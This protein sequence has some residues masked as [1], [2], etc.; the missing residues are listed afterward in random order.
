MTQQELKDIPKTPQEARRQ[1]GPVPLMA[2]FLALGLFAVLFLFFGL[3][4]IDSIHDD[5]QGTAIESRN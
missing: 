2:I 3:P 4:L 1:K 5:V